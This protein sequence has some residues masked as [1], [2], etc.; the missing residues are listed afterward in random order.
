MTD[1][2][3]ALSHVLALS[4]HD[5]AGKTTT[6]RAFADLTGGVVISLA[7]LLK[8]QAA[9]H[10][11]VPVATLYAKPTPEHLRAYMRALGWAMRVEHGAGYWLQ[12]WHARA[13]ESGARVVIVDDVRHVNEAEYVL[14]RGAALVSVTR[15][16]TDPALTPDTP[17]II[18]E[19]FDIRRAVLSRYA[20]H[21]GLYRR[22]R[23]LD[24]NHLT[25]HGA[26]RVLA[27]QFGFTPRG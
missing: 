22:S 3:R 13:A 20:A 11:G 21:N 25:P 8:E 14:E 10:L 4:G 2:S 27:E 26:A 1:T 23:T 17:P 18:R 6:A 9:A 16:G 5:G 12:A 15:A 7:D 19:V 24:L